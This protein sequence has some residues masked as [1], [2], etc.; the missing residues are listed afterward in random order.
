MHLQSRGT[1]N[2]L[3]LLYIDELRFR[4]KDLKEVPGCL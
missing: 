3:P 4:I 1:T 2:Y